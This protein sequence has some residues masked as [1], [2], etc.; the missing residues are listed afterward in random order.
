MPP[1]KKSSKPKNSSE[2][3]HEKLRSKL[4]EYLILALPI[5][6]VNGAVVW[7]M[8]RFFSQ[9]WQILWFAVPM[10]LL[11]WLAWRRVVGRPDAKLGK[12]F[13]LLFSL[14]V[15]IFSLAASSEFLNWKRSL[16]GYNQAV[17]RNFLALNWAGDWRY[18]FVR[19][20]EP[21]TDFAI[22]VKPPGQPLEVGRV[23]IAQLI[24]F[25]VANGV[26]GI[27][28]DFHFRDNSLPEIDEK[29][30]TAIRKA[31]PKV[32]IFV[33]YGFEREINS[34]EITWKGVA[35]S[36]QA[37][38][39]ETRQG[40]TVA[41]AELDNKIRLVPLYF[42]KDPNR[43]SL[44]LKIARELRKDLQLPAD[45][46]VHFIKPEQNFPEINLDEVSHQKARLKDKFL[47]VGER[48]KN[49]LWQT[50][51]GEVPGVL[52]HSYVV[53]SLRQ[54]HFLRR[55]PW[56]SSFVMVFAACYLVTFFFA[57]GW[58]RLKILLMTLLVSTTICLISLVAVAFWLD[59]LD[60]IYPLVAIWLLFILLLLLSKSLRVSKGRSPKNAHT[61]NSKLSRNRPK[62]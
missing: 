46:L 2:P 39:S 42:K 35:P 45:G 23:K 50:P 43:E 4:N 32:P 16:Q 36:L 38:I 24:E 53:H 49:D 30:C 21:D 10:T 56:W 6:L 31:E 13:L 9:P 55:V 19:Q 57:Q 33:G 25:A 17:P 51:Y 3:F 59:W 62:S 27:A 8:N 41:Y 1:R 14:Y 5:A 54:N 37:C 44:G 28:F 22:I 15:L 60:V 12:S 29:L 61:G 52:I 20:T 11:A 34:G 26:K 18:N 40:H 7:L 47:L 48:G 58:S